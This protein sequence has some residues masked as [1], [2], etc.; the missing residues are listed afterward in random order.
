MSDS[1]DFAPQ[2]TSAADRVR[3]SRSSA[4]GTSPAGGVASADTTSTTQ[5][6]SAASASR[7]RRR[8]GGL[9]SLVLPELQALAAELG[10]TGTARM[11]KS[12]LIE[13]ITAR[14][15][16]SAPVTDRG[17]G[18]AVGAAAPATVGDLVARRRPSAGRAGLQR[19]PRRRYPPQPASRRHS[20]S[21]PSR[22]H[23]GTGG[24]QPDAARPSR[25]AR[26]A[27]AGRGEREDARTSRGERHQR[28]AATSSVTISSAP[29]RAA[30]Q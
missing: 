29:R 21:E 1:T 25:S 11:R 2:T 20:D 14:Q 24:Q 15:G 28:R 8:A 12:Q 4:D 6:A 22:R 7:A 9:A 3:R 10:I 18:R 27:E 23:F 16:G 17:D 5:S 13:A 30:A 26:R 19:P